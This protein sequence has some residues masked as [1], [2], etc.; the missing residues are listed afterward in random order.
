MKTATNILLASHGTEGARAAEKMA[1][2]LCEKGAKLHH[3]LVVPTLWEGMTGD[4]W[5]NNGSTRDTFRRYLESELGKEV[6]EHCDRIS[7]QAKAMSVTYSNE[8]IVGE[9][10]KCLLEACKEQNFEL[11]VMGSPRPKGMQ[12][13]RSRMSTEPLSRSLSVPL[14]IVPYPQ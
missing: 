10:E 11:V 12:G 3:L 9:P 6:D 2:S 14:L 8:L 4:D 13:L 7:S 1:F 5:L